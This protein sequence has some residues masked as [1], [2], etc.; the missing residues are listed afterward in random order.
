MVTQNIDLI[1]C[2]KQTK[3]QT[4]LLTC[5]PVSELPCNISTMRFSLLLFDFTAAATTVYDTIIWVAFHFE[6]CAV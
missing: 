4:L 6:K 1:E 3:K 2:F 5:A